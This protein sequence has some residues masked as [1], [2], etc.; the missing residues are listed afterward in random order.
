MG[1]PRAWALP[2]EGLVDELQLVVMPVMPGGGK[3]VFPA[4]GGQRTWE[5]VSSATGKTG[6]QVNVFRRAAEES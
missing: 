6:V 5:L 1:C 4:D 3:S 2:A